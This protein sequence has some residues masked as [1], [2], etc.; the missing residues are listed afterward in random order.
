VAKDE[1]SSLPGHGWI[2]TFGEETSRPAICEALARGEYFA[3]SGV[4]LRRIQVDG[5]TF[6]VSTAE[7]NTVVAFIGNGGRVLATET[8]TPSDDGFSAS[9]ALKGGE[10]YVRAR[11]TLT[12]GGAAWTQA[13]RVVR[14]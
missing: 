11:A 5:T 13:Y 9:Y 6:R 2:E 8:V 10:P 12:G 1:R 7:P 4:R 3:S 14:R